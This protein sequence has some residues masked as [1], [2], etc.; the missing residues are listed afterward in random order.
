MKDAE[1]LAETK[2]LNLDVSPLDGKTITNLLIELY[3][4][5]KSVLEKA[6]QAT[7]K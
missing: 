7:S 5:P 1:F 4:T 2:K 6:A 3:A